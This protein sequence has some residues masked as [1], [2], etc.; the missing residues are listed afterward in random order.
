MRRA[1]LSDGPRVT[2]ELI[3]KRKADAE[4]PESRVELEERL[5][6]GDCVGGAIVRPF[7]GW[8]GEM[9]EVPAG[10]ASQRSEF[11]FRELVHRE[12]DRE[13]IG[14]SLSRH[15]PVTEGPR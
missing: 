3:G 7:S 12:D 14:P 15:T 8:T 4:L 11:V 13:G 6:L 5:A 9:L 1:M 2:A 10:R